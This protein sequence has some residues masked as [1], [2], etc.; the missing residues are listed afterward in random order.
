MTIRGTKFLG[1]LGLVL[2]AAIVLAP[3]AKAAPLSVYGELPTME[4]LAIAPDGRTLAYVTSI[5]GARTVFI[6]SIADKRGL[7]ALKAGSEKLRDLS[8]AGNDHLLITASKTESVRGVGA[9]YE[10]YAA[11]IY[12]VKSNEF[13]PLLKRS[14]PLYG[15]PRVRTVDGAVKVIIETAVG[16]RNYQLLAID[17]AN[18]QRDFVED[19]SRE[20]AQWIIDQNGQ[21]L[22]RTIYE[23]DQKRWRLELQKDDDWTVAH[24]I[25]VDIDMPGI[26]GLSHDGT[27]VIIEEEGENGYLRKAVSLADGKLV[28]VPGEEYN[29]ANLIVNPFTQ[30]V[31]GAA[32][33]TMS[34]QYWFSDVEDQKKW[35]RVTAAFPG[36]HVALVSWSQDR[37]TVIVEIAGTKTGVVY[38]LVDLNKNSA[39]IIGKAYR[40]LE[41]A[42]VAPVRTLTYATQDGL[43]IPAYLTVP[44]GTDAKGLPLIVLVHGGPAAR[45]APGFDWW[46]QAFA[47]RGYAVLQ[48]QFRGSDGL[49]SKLLYAGYG[50]WGRKMQ[51]DLSD[52]V[53]S[54]AEKDI[55]D[56]ARVCI[57]GASYGG[58]AALAGM[59]FEPDMY[60]CGVSIAGI[61]DV[62]KMLRDM[63]RAARNRSRSIKYWQRF[64]GSDSVYD[65][66]IDQIS[67]AEHARKVKG[68]ILLFHGKDDIVVEM[69]QTDIMHEALKRAKKDVRYVKLEEEDHWFSRS[70]TRRKMLEETVSFIEQHNPASKSP[71]AGGN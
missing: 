45:D 60:K 34:T 50:Q 4:Q 3:L 26:V 67:P 24:E 20:T 18:G 31:I 38:G 9:V 69:E 22:G 65:D 64:A 6:Q 62:G 23:S 40:G 15:V 12:D 14:E 30:R 39:L 13:R 43:E 29:A 48:P 59:T 10:Y 42:D 46:S 51:T 2:S 63:P 25:K 61:S 36:E 66:I 28:D 57:V 55:I 5:E 35:Q 1:T 37:Q 32:L 49:G 17:V 44:R 41:A 8:W 53:K 7:A 71:A 11:N 54:L 21:A 47:S 16:G 68:P 70:A 56:P 27:S 58:Y 33:G 52:G 19:A